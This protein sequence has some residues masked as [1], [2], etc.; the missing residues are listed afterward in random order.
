MKSKQSLIRSLFLATMA[1]AL[2]AGCGG[3]G[4]GNNNDDASAPAPTPATA[5]WGR[6][7]TSG[8]GE[9]ARALPSIAPNTVPAHVVDRTRALQSVFWTTDNNFD[10]RSGIAPPTPRLASNIVVTAES[11]AVAGSRFVGQVA[12]LL[13]TGATSSS[14]STASAAITCGSDSGPFAG[15]PRDAG[16]E[17]IAFDGMAHTLRLTNLA[18]PGADSSLSGELRYTPLA[19]QAGTGGTTTGLSA[20]LSLCPSIA[21]EVSTAL[22]WPDVGC[23]GGR[24]VGTSDDDKPCTVDVDLVTR[25][26]SANIDGYAQSYG[27]VAQLE[28]SQQ[29]SDEAVY[30]QGTARDWTYR[31][32]RQATAGAR[33]DDAPV[34][35]LIVNFGS[36][37][38]V[39][40]GQVL[41]VAAAVFHTTAPAGAA[42]PVDVKFC[43]AALR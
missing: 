17:A 8:S 25:V 43:R 12:L 21:G 34:D 19:L 35:Q 23:L 3:G 37:T 40:G 10:A 41:S 9:I 16:C 36:D 4:G 14:A 6:V 38:R 32:A 15:L 31:F 22:G 1:C 39:E 5:L 7:T 20:A 11:G 42:G 30:G 24:F 18:L 26:A 28:Y 13:Q 29:S 33:I 2:A 27:F